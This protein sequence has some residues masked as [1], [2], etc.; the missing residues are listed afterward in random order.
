MSDTVAITG[1]AGF[2]GR[3]CCK[4]FTDAGFRVRALVRNPECAA[5]LPDAMRCNLPDEIDPH[6]FEGGVRALVHCAYE[7]RSASAEQARRTN[8]AGTEALLTRARESGVRQL[9]FV[10]SM[11]AHERARSV[12]GCTKLELEKQFTGA[13][14]TVIKPGVILGRGGLFQ[15]TREMAG[16]VPVLPLFYGGGELQTVWIDDICAAIVRA[17]ERE[18]TG[19]L[20]IA[21][22]DPVPMA[23]FYRGIA[24]LDGKHPKLVALPGDLALLGIRMLEG[25]GMKPP[26][27]SDNLLGIKYL[28]RFDTRAD[29]ERAGV[30]ALSFAESLKR[31]A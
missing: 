14:D 5:G 12:Y 6:A 24:A 30:R 27:S 21:H 16:K 23:E 22:P 8:V 10:S 13:H 1:A 31:L 18:L 2:L 26:I 29:L 25:L 9:L 17:V 3:A 15:R 11:A 4:A 19:T 20:A 28:H 7:T